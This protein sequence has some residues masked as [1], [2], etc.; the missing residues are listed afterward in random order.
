MT[1]WNLC[2]RIYTG[3]ERQYGAEMPTPFRGM[4]ATYEEIEAVMPPEKAPMRGGPNMTL[5]EVLKRTKP[6]ILT[7]A[8]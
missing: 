1:P 8:G 3:R 4:A 6:S 5:Q 7:V 2:V